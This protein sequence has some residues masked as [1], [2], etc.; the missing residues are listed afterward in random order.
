MIRCQS[1]ICFD[2]KKDYFYSHIS[3]GAVWEGL[4]IKGADT[5][6]LRL[7]L[8]LNAVFTLVYNLSHNM[9]CVML[10]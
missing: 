4:I 1:F 6:C 7:L 5:S 8:L 2:G 3:G 9:Q 10:G